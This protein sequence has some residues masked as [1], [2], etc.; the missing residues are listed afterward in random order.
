MFNKGNLGGKGELGQIDHINN[1]PNGT[2]I[3]IKK[4]KYSLNWQTPLKVI[5]F[6]KDNLIKIDE[7]SIFDIYEINK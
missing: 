2:K 4:D 1:L 5:N 6:V 3:L 7:I